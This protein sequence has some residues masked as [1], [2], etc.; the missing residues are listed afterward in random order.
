MEEFIIEEDGDDAADGAMKGIKAKER[1]NYIDNIVST[2]EGKDLGWYKKILFK[3]PR[4]KDEQLTPYELKVLKD[5][6]T[7]SKSNNHNKQ[8]TMEN[9]PLNGIRAADLRVLHELILTR[10]KE[11]SY[12]GNKAQYYER[13][14]RLDKWIGDATSYA[15]SEA[16]YE[17][18]E[19]QL[20]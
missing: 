7:A 1:L 13:L 16:V 8:K 10:K 12:Y 2:Y 17:T 5:T 4:F 9:I 14:D 19:S 20:Y 6:Y 11:G 15:H 18:V 3:N